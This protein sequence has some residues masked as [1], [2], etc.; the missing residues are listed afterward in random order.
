MHTKYIWFIA[1]IVTSTQKLENYIS[2]QKSWLLP[3]PISQIFY[4]K[5][6]KHFSI[7]CIF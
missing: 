7:L 5:G 4:F 6:F 3:K 2:L 1:I